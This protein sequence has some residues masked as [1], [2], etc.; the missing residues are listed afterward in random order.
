MTSKVSPATFPFEA[1][2]DHNIQ[3]TKPLEN[4]GGDS[5]GAVKSVEAA[6]GVTSSDGQQQ[7]QQQQDQGMH[8]PCL[9]GS[10]HQPCSGTL[11][12]LMA[13]EEI[14]PG[15][16]VISVPMYLLAG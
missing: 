7:Q 5:V 12:G 14:L 8:S 13:K 9:R 16:V 1:E 2:A 3:S 4:P 6:Q 15:D 10:P 11:R